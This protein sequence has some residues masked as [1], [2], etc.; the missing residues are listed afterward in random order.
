G[1]DYLEACQRIL[2]DI[3]EA[4]ALAASRRVKA[5]GLLRINVP[6]SFGSRFVAPLLPGF[7][8][9]HPEVRVELGL[10]D[11]QADLV[12]G[13][14]DLAIRIGRLAASPLQARRLGD[15]NML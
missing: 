4:E 8:R 3:D 2:P 7:S 1:S 10:N 13:R 14:W 6:V 11:A 9:Q 15:C 5:A 12:A